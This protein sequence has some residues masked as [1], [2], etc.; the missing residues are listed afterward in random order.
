MSRKKPTSTDCVH[1]GRMIFESPHSVT[2]PVV[3]SSP[4]E[5]ASTDELLDFMEGRS[6]RVQP[7]YGR[8]GNPTV[9]SVERHLAELDRAEESQ[10]FSS[11][12]AAVTSLFL[13]S[14]RKG[15]HLIITGDSYRRT[16]DFAGSLSKFGIS[17]T[18]VEASLDCVSK[19][20]QAETRLIFAEVPTNPYLNVLDIEELARLGRQ[21]EALTVIDATFATP[22]NLSPLDHG[23]DLVIHSATK[24]LGGHNDLIAGVLSGSRRLVG[25]VSEFLMT[26]GAI[27][28]PH[29]AFLL[30]RGLKTLAVRVDQHNRSARAIAEFLEAHPRIQRVFYPGLPSHPH[31]AIARRLMS[32]FGGV[33]S[34]LFDGDLKESLRFLDR[35]KIPRLAP[36]FGGAE[37]LIEPVA[38]MSYWNSPRE[39]RQRIGIPDNLIRFSAGLEDTSDLVADLKA[40]LG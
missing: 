19:A 15:D 32:G 12:M 6:P 28:D 10:L 29:T 37:S 40:A 7:E 9:R 22:L 17:H 24:Y 4:F 23:I 14:L 11:G 18:I 3:Y 27:S 39:E 25:P 2:T 20:I 5:F 21:A 8:M 13:S 30:E 38:V 16:R 34:F 26:L 35:L 31:H 1:G 33:V 36:S